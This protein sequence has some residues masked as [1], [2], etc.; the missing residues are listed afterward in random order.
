MSLSLFTSIA[1]NAEW[2]QNKIGWWFVESNSYYKDC[3]K[4]INGN[5]YHFDISGYM[6]KSK[7]IDGYYINDDGVWSNGNEEIN[8]YSKELVDYSLLRNKYK[9]NIKDSKFF[10][11]SRILY[12]KVIY[13]NLMISL[14]N[15]VK[16]EKI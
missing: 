11:K 3:W 2:R 5:W 16:Q 4:E 7:I 15:M 14:S 8:A 1:A 10:N 6:D 12:R 9:M 13:K